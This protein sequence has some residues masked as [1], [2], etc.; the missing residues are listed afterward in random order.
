MKHGSPGWKTLIFKE[1]SQNISLF[2]SIIFLVGC[3]VLH[4][5]VTLFLYSICRLNVQTAWCIY[6]D[7]LFQE[8]LTSFPVWQKK[9]IKEWVSN[10]TYTVG[11]GRHSNEEVQEMV[12]ENLRQFSVLLGEALYMILYVEIL[13]FQ[14]YSIRP[15]RGQDKSFRSL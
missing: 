12:V 9:S 2:V 6:I 4:Q 14:I 5:N 8:E 3:N 11:I 13:D 10:M 7:E 1:N 15:S